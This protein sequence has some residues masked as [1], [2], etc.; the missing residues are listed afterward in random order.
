MFYRAEIKN[1]KE[2]ESS[3]LLKAVLL[4]FM[5]HGSFV[6]PLPPIRALGPREQIAEGISACQALTWLS[7]LLC[8]PW[9]PRPPQEGP[10]VRVYLL[11]AWCTLHS[12]D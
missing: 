6:L 9:I 11:S 10:C 3:L 2:A 4:S 5:K 7:T 12:N 8:P 1:H